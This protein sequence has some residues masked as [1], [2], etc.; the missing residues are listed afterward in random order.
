MTSSSF[1]LS[2]FNFSL[3]SELPRE[4]RVNAAFNQCGSNKSAAVHK[5]QVA[6]LHEILPHHAHRKA[7]RPSPRQS[8]VYPGIR[9]NC[10]A[11]EAINKICGSIPPNS[12]W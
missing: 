8:G 7:F 5:F 2:R 6:I 12:M 10:S 3:V 9:G 4:L 11:L 1:L